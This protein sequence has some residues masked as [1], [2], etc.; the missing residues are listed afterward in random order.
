[1]G[2]SSRRAFLGLSGG[3][4]ASLAAGGCR[5]PQGAQILAA[6]SLGPA[7]TAIVRDLGGEHPCTLILAGSQI[8]ATQIL[9]GAPVDLFASADEVQ[10]ARAQ[11]SDR[12]ATPRPFA[13]NEV[14][15]AV[16]RQSSVAV[17]TPGDL[18]TAG[19]RLV[20]AAEEVPAGR[21]ARQALEHADLLE[22][23][24]GHVVSEE[25]SVQGV[26]TKLVTGEADAGLVYRTD[27]LAHPE[28]LTLVE[29]PEPARVEATYQLALAHRPDNAAQA[30]LGHL[31]SPEG[32]ATLERFGFGSVA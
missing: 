3:L 30:F 27:A 4:V 11:S 25:D 14:V 16:S 2:G 1:M 24:L 20:L 21:Y 15:V 19:L 31:R 7:F 9:E 29:L 22:G 5:P 18:D 23:A 12:L 10:M 6:A 26:V 28:A 8:L 13:V 17:S 32:I